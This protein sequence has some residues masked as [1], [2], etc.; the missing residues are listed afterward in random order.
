MN[1]KDPIEEELGKAGVAP[2]VPPSVVRLDK[3]RIMS[4][5][6]VPPEEFLMRLFG[7]P[8]EWNLGKLFFDAMGVMPS[9]T[10]E[11]LQNEVMAIS[12]IKQPKY[13]DKVFKLAVD[14]RI[15]QTTMDKHGRVVVILI[16][17]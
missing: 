15:V 7:K 16:P 8:W 14:Q 4:D 10:L 6:D 5:T 12:G 13:Y 9:L 3:F 2:S 1:G 17:S 11:A